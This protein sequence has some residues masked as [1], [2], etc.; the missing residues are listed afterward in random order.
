MCIDDGVLRAKLDGELPRVDSLE[1]DAH[2]AG[3]TRCRARAEEIAVRARQ[4]DSFLTQLAPAPGR[5]PAGAD[6]AYARFQGRLRQAAEGPRPWWRLRPAWGLAAAMAVAVLMAGSPSSRALAQK[7]LGLFRVK[8]VVVV[9]VDFDIYS[10][11]K[12]KLL[13]QV[14]ADSVTVTKDEPA[15]V[16]A[17]KQDAA[18]T[19]GFTVRLPAMRQ[20]APQ[21]TV[22]GEH[23]FNLTVKIDRV[24]A[25]LDILG[26][27]DLQP[28]PGLAGA[29]VVVDVPRAV[30]AAY[31]N[32]PQA[33]RGPPPAG[34]DFGDCIIL[35][36][37][38]TPTVVTLPDL[39][40]SE[41][42]TLGLQ[43]AGMTA[44]QAAQFSR[45]VDWT[46]TLAIPLPRG[47]GD[48]QSVQVNG[49]PATLIVMKSREKRPAG[50]M[51]IWIKDGIVYSVT[52]FGNPGLA[53]PLAESLG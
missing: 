13:S 35:V 47:E 15:R 3:C 31:G 52:G 10:E 5:A 46:S 48:Y 37:A 44:E 9:P 43:L 25:T 18:G 49:A 6:A 21:L 41:I 7:L 32:C 4:V 2:L 53:V 38:P 26:R 19:A 27:P 22:E 17:T 8:S 34:G 12:G 33:R 36:Q 40:L 24:R 45:T 11:G 29:K 51:L 20:D 23:A 30:R 39:N 42:A 28:P 14:L 50:Y 16:A 1:V